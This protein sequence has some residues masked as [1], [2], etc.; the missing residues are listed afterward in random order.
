MYRDSTAG[1]PC[2][3]QRCAD[4]Y[5]CRAFFDGNLEIAGHAHGELGERPI[6]ELGHFVAQLAQAAKHGTRAL[7]IGRN[8]RYGHQAAQLEMRHEEEALG[9]ARQVRRFAAG[10]FGRGIQAD[11]DEHRQPAA[12]PGGVIELFGEGQVIDGIHGVK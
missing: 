6:E 7:G 8:R 10:L 3:E 5:L 9:Q 2:A 4:T 12:V 11:F 1:R